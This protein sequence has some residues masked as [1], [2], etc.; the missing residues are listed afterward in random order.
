MDKLLE[1]LKSLQKVTPRADWK[2]MNRE[3]LLAQIDMQMGEREN[4]RSRVFG[5]VEAYTPHKLFQFVA[6]PVG[7]L[8]LAIFVI[9]SSGALT[10]N[11]A[12]GSLPGDMLYG[13]KITTE[14]IQSGLTFDNNKKAELHTSFAQNR[15]NEINNI[16]TSETD[17]EKKIQRIMEATDNLKE[18]LVNVQTTLDKAINTSQDKATA[19]LTVATA[20]AVNIA[21]ESISQE[22]TKQV[23]EIK[24]DAVALQQMKDAVATTEATGVKAVEVI[25]SKY[26]ND[27]SVVNPVTVVTTLQQ[28]LQQAEEKINQVTEL[29]KTVTAPATEVTTPTTE[30]PTT[31]TVEAPDEN[32]VNAEAVRQVLTE[33]ENYIKQGDLAGAIQKIRESALLTSEAEAVL[34]IRLQEMLKATTATTV[35]TK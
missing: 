3:R 17:P 16:N 25:V 31:T 10:V 30:T 13:V 29:S 6:R 19:T 2:A 35:E 21:V 12:L 34:E 11:A 14:K 7:A 23:G 33:A 18:D 26:D 32:V 5:F 15:V 20:Q 28:K 1:Q 4:V 8:V 27:N 24:D 9:V 22:L